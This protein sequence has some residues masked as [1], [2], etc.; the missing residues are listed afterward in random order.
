MPGSNYAVFTFEAGKNLEDTRL[1]SQM[2][3]RYIKYQWAVMNN[4]FM[5]YMNYIFEEFSDTFC[6][7]YIP[8]LSGMGGI[9]LEKNMDNG[10]DDWIRY[11]DEHI[12][13][14][15]TVEKTAEYFYY[16]PRH[17]RD[18]FKMYYDMELSDY[19]RRRRLYRIAKAI[20]DDSIPVTDISSVFHVKSW[21]S[22]CMEFWN[23]FHTK[24]EDYLHIK[25]DI[26]SLPEY[27]TENRKGITVTSQ[28]INPLLMIG[29]PL[30]NACEADE[31]A[32]DIPGLC[33]HF[34]L[35]DPLC[36]TDT[37]YA[38]KEGQED[39]AALWIEDEINGETIY[40]Y[41]L[42]PVVPSCSQIPPGM[43][44]ALIKGGQYAVFTTEKESGNLKDTY[45]M[46]TICVFYGWI[47]EN[48]YRVDFERITFSRY[49]NGKLYFYVP[50][51][52]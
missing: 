52:A 24:P 9:C 35:H 11:I 2:A 46:L 18:V 10:I 6:S 45:R 23:E 37:A 38:S 7:I 43:K 28:R 25:N 20:K 49:K 26:I 30:K 19:I 21:R 17:F 36:L 1:T 27:Y 16:S 12:F 3:A 34:Y 13:E 41:I 51:Y 47:K 14:N 5:D 48:R 15:L 22:F 42:G 44:K 33:Q 50:I 39:K 32:L 4:K 31:S 40:S 8:L 29:I